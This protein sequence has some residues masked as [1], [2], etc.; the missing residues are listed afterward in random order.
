M[1]MAIKILI[2]DDEEF[3]HKV[4]T[5]ILKSESYHLF[6]ANNG[7]E[8]LDVAQKEIPD[9]IFLDINMPK[10]NGNE[11]LK[12]LKAGEKT[13]G[14]PVL[15]VSGNGEMVDK[16]VGYELGVEDYLTKPFDAS[17]LIERINSIVSKQ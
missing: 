1:K 15:M 16:V 14:I 12:E 13:F 6:H 2:V 11:T 8:C 9:I 3:I 5:R 7:L 10:M 4:L 17:E